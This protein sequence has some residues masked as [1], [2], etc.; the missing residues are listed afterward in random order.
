M[1]PYIDAQDYED[2]MDHTFNN[3][4]EAFTDLTAQGNE[5]LI[6]VSRFFARELVIEVEH[7]DPGLLRFYQ[8]D[9]KLPQP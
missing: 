1:L 4:E 8:K 2:L 7:I 6:R 3:L 5:D 9:S